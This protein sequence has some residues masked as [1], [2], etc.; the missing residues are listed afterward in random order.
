VPEEDSINEKSRLDSVGEESQLVSPNEESHLDVDGFDVNMLRTQDY[1]DMFKQNIQ[2]Q[3]KP[4]LTHL[5]HQNSHHLE[6][7]INTDQ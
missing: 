3:P 4:K 5:L 2:S 7:N 1:M 6:M